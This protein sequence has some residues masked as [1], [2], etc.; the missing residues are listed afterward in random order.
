MINPDTE[1]VYLI[2]EREL[3]NLDAI[4]ISEIKNE[5][6]ALKATIFITLMIVVIITISKLLND[7]KQSRDENSHIR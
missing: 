5:N 2:P 6:K 1:N 4:N 7:T 3:K